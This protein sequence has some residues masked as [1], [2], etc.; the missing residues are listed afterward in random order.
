MNSYQAVAER[1]VTSGSA[2]EARYALDAFSQILPGLSDRDRSSIAA[3]YPALEVRL[4]QKA[5]NR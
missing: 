3:A 4:R 5:E 2:A 1:I